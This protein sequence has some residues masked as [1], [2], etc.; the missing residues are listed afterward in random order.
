MTATLY[1]SPSGDFSIERSHAT[2][3]FFAFDQYGAM[4]EVTVSLDQLPAI[5][6]ALGEY[7]EVDND[8]TGAK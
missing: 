1:E 7:L 5:Y 8:A 3:W 4:S 6:K 2:L